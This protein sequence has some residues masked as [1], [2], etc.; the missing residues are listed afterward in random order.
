MATVKRRRGMTLV[1]FLVAAGLA[2]SLLAA[3]CGLLAAHTRL[4]R[5]LEAHAAAAH[6]VRLV[7]DVMSRDL[8]RAGFDPGVT[9]LAPIAAA[10]TRAIVVQ[11]DDNGDGVVD[12]R[13]GERTAYAF[14][15]DTGVLYRTVGRQPMP[16]AEGLSAQGFT[17]AYLDREGLAIPAV[18]GVSVSDLP[19]IH[20]VLI[21]VA[22]GSDDGA[23]LAQVRTAV[24]LR[25][26]L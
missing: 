26:F 19:R 16:L 1:E 10:A 7:F 12:L 6:T 5:H 9:G 20:R 4:Y 18:E 13:S 8:R 14:R 15:P 17:L 25:G 21:S 24:V 22:A 11:S 2:A 23:P 3:L